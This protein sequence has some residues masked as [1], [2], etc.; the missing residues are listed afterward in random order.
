MRVSISLTVGEHISRLVETLRVGFCKKR[1]NLSL[2]SCYKTYKDGC[3]NLV[4]KNLF[5]GIVFIIIGVLFLL[6]NLNIFDL[7]W[8]IF[9]SS[10]VLII[11]Y[12]FKKDTLYLIIGLGLFAFSSVSLIDRYVFTNINIKIFIYLFVGGCGLL[13]FYY[14]GH[15]RN[16]LIIGSILIALAF[17]HLFGQLWP[18]FLPW[19]KYFILSLSFYLCYLVAYRTNG[20]VWPRY[21]SYIMLGI[22]GIQLFVNRDILRF[23]NFK[24]SYLFPVFI[25]LI[26]IRIVYLARLK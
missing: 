17:N 10:I 11:R 2:E 8:I 13:Y 20:I 4:K 1:K 15:E 24:F 12:I 18:I 5:T 9:L 23:A 14:K 22:G 16:W 26:G 3:D 21:I 25:I 6:Y 19:G 7:A